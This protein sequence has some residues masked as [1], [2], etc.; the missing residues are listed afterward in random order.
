MSSNRNSNNA[1]GQSNRPAAGQTAKVTESALKPSAANVEGIEEVSYF[2]SAGKEAK[3]R[4]PVKLR[5]EGAAI[6]LAAIPAHAKIVQSNE[7]I[8]KLR[9]QTESAVHA[10]AVACQKM[11]QRPNGPDFSNAT[12]IFLA[13]TQHAEIMAKA[14]WE[15]MKENKGLAWKI[16]KLAP[17]WTG[18]V[19]AIKNG[20][21]AAKI[22]KGVDLLATTTE[23]GSDGETVTLP[24]FPSVN[25]VRS[26]T[27]TRRNRTQ[28]LSAGKILFG[29]T[30]A[31]P[32]LKTVLKQFGQ[33]LSALS[34]DL[35]ND[36]AGILTEALG[37]VEALSSGA[38]TD[39]EVGAGNDV[40]AHNRSQG[41]EDDGED[42][43]EGDAKETAKQVARRGGSR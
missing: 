20:W 1:S 18:A 27:T 42:G 6:I 24:S 25:A 41:E 40:A 37:L 29:L 26:E 36:A 31:T 17:E 7:L 21:D 34:P 16:S 9:K 32:A 23:K 2:N 33:A 43:E 8:K 39:A 38:A 30:D 3:A 35:Q 19:S 28:E 14:T 12:A 22:G 11:T 4:I 13:V 5:E 15:A 10:I